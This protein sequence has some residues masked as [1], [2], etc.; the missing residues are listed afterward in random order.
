MSSPYVP[1]I[2]SPA[3]HHNDVTTDSTPMRTVTLSARR[4]LMSWSISHA[5][6]IHRTGPTP[7]KIRAV[8]LTPPITWTT[9]AKIAG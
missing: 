3:I 9:N 6:K 2:S 7:A 8:A 5:Y 1:C 4:Q